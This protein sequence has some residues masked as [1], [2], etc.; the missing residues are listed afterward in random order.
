MG[1]QSFNTVMNRVYFLLC[2]NYE[3]YLVLVGMVVKVRYVPLDHL[4]EVLP[5]CGQGVGRPPCPSFIIAPSSLEDRR[6]FTE[7]RTLPTLERQFGPTVYE[8]YGHKF[9]A[10][11]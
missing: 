7:A 4:R 6:A 9:V 1:Y 10:R 3:V 2:A 11:G 8:P 5:G